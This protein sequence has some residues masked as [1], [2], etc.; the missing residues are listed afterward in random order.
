MT[1]SGKP[2]FA[3]LNQLPNQV[4]DSLEPE[5]RQPKELPFPGVT[6][7]QVTLAFM[8]ACDAAEIE[9]FSLHDLR[10]TFASQLRMKGADLHTVGQLLGHKDLRM[11]ARCSHLNPEFSRDRGDKLDEVF[12][13]PLSWRGV[14]PNE[15]TQRTMV[16]P[17]PYVRLTSDAGIGDTGHPFP[18]KE[19]DDGKR[20]D[21]EC[22]SHVDLRPGHRRTGDE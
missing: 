1:E 7:E 17:A 22:S 15:T 2:R 3:Y 6:P 11:T 12:T 19:S 20:T 16:S 8:R 18:K 5:G 9:D 21:P 14:I 13:E 4:I 10:H